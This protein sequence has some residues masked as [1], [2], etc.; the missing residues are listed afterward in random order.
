MSEAKDFPDINVMGVSTFDTKV[1]LR[2]KPTLRN[3]C[4]EK[5]SH[6]VSTGQ[7]QLPTLQ[8]LG[9]DVMERVFHHLH[10]AKLLTTPDIILGLVTPY[11]HTLNL[12]LCQI[13]DDQLF[14]NI[15]RK[16]TQLRVV[17]I[18]ACHNVTNKGIEMLAD[19]CPYLEYLNMANGNTIT[20]SAIAAIVDRCPN[21]HSFNLSA[22][23]ALD[24]AVMVFLGKIRHQLR[25]VSICGCRFI[26]R[27]GVSALLGTLCGN[28]PLSPNSNTSSNSASPNSIPNYANNDEP[29]DET[30]NNAP[31][32]PTIVPQANGTIVNYTIP[33]CKN[34]CLHLHSFHVSNCKVDISDDSIIEL[35]TAAPNLTSLNVCGIK[36]LSDKAVYCLANC[37]PN[38]Q[39]LYASWCPISDAAFSYLA[40]RCAEL[41]VLNL[42]GCRHIGTP[43]CVA[44]A[45]YCHKLQKVNLGST[46]MKFEGAVQI[47]QN[48]PLLKTFDIRLCALTPAQKA[49]LRVISGD[50]HI[51]L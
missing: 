24:N 37:C 7:I 23:W 4:L 6:L 43:S 15:L 8:Q 19:Y 36:N 12:P 17:N 9:G 42:S 50:V 41:A 1:R 13:L 32:T 28:S 18:S 26:S 2:K 5:V 30:L 45:T 31:T 51:N 35:A 3:L 46:I 10:C 39:E 22:C 21:V 16:C 40:Q 48:S 49:H 11:L 14:E 29:P 44:L 33:N 27:S 47:I 38:L 25:F 34:T 20:S